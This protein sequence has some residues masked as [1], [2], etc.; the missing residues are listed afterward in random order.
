LRP[1]NPA[2]HLNRGTALYD[3]GEVDAAIEDYHHSLAL[4]PQYFAAHHNLGLAL[5]VTGRLD[6]AIAEFREAIRLNKDYPNAHNGL[7]AALAERGQLEE[8]IAAY[9]EAIRIKNDFAEAHCNLGQLLCNQGQFAAALEELRKGH[10]LGSKQPG[11]HYLFAQRVEVIERLAE[12]AP[13]VPAILAG[14][15]KPADDAE[16]LALARFCRG[17]FKQLYAASARLFAEAFANDAK[18]ADDVVSGNRYDAACAAA[19]AGC[20][21]GNDADKLESEDR[22]RLRRQ[23][24]DWLRADLAVWGR[25]L[26]KEP[27]Q[28]LS[29]AR[30]TTGLQRWLVA[31]EFAGVRGPEALAGLP[32]AER[33]PWQQLWD[34][35]AGMVAQP[36]AKATPMKKSDAK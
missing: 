11:W 6:E 18:L 34:D 2:I 9:R 22:S 15:A 12:M 36:K 35:V 17:R 24:L 20:G 7:G 1:D 27:D 25:V 23:A 4:A 13:K 31:P 29:V 5:Y 28:A 30:V 10:E 14:K 8:A 21:Q 33:Q 19:L 32:E 16:R 26:D 3:A